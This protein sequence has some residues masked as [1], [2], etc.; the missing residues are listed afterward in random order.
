MGVSGRVSGLKLGSVIDKALR[1]TRQYIRTLPIPELFHQCTKDIGCIQR[2]YVTDGCD[3]LQRFKCALPRE[4]AT[5][6]HHNH[7]INR[8]YGMCASTP[9][10]GNKRGNKGNRKHKYCR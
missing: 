1:T 9:V 10:I 6:V 5:L 3:K 4:L 8:I 2:V 7:I